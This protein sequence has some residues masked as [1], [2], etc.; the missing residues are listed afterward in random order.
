MLDASRLR[1]NLRAFADQDY[2]PFTE[3][4]RT[5]DDARHAWAAAFD[6]YFGQVAELVPAPPPGHPAFVTTAVDGA[7]FGDLGLVP[8]L[9]ASDAATDFA[10]AWKAAIRAVSFAAV[11]DSSGNVWTPS[12][13]TNVDPLGDALYASLLALFTSFPVPPV[14]AVARLGDIADAFHAASSGLVATVVVVN[15][16][17]VTLPTVTMSVH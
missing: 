10:G 6:D 15:S 17:G 13:F 8:T 1:D 5:R 4:P 3:F 9:S 12:V 11:T 16:S 2:A 7:F 14:T